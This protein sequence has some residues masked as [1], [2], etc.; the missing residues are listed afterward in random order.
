MILSLF[1]GA[2]GLDSGF[3]SEGFEIGLAFDIRAAAIESYNFNRNSSH[4]YVRDISKLTVSD[5]DKIYGAEFKPTGVIGGPP[6][7]SF[8]VSNVSGRNDDARHDL[9]LAYAN[10]LG[11]L[12][13]R[14]PIHFFVFEN[15]LGLKSEKH[16]E[17]YNNFKLAFESAGFVLQEVILN[18]SQ[19]GV[20]QDRKRIFIIGLNKNIYPA[21]SFSFERAT[22]MKT[23]RESIAHLPE[24]IS[25]EQYK[26]GHVINHHANHWC[27]TPKSKKFKTPG[28]LIPGKALGRSFRVLD[29]DKPSPTVAYGHREVHIHPNCHRRLSVHEASIL[30]GFPIDFEFRGTMSSQFTQVSEAVPPVV[31]K[32][33]AKSI[34][35]F[36]KYN[37]YEL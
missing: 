34:K 11:Q 37:G 8:S 17:K 19:F 5:I 14:N 13:K 2:G 4:G 1:C 10:L 18:A 16:I 29:W 20:P 15:V 6:C 25:Y 24:P 35:Y 30:Q 12:N 36:A 7:Q 21:F 31:S 26:N 33:L 32:E 23:V 3:E 28:A 9:P 22:V 27:M